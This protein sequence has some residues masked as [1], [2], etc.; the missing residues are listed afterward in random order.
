M[1]T[2]LFFQENSNCVD[3]QKRL[4]KKTQVRMDSQD[5]FVRN[6]SMSDA[7]SKLTN[8]LKLSAY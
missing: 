5:L 6:A 7:K 3:D 8:L 4:Q 2:G 1:P